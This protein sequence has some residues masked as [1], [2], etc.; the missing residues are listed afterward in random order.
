MRSGAR[1]LIAA[2]GFAA[3]GLSACGQAHQF[4]RQ[5]NGDHTLVATVD[6][7]SAN[8]GLTH[9]TAISVQEKRGLATNVATF[10][11]V[12]APVAVSWLGPEDLSICQSGTLVGHRISVDLNT[13][14]GKRTVHIHY[15][16][17]GGI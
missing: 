16:C 11:N 10:R 7:F 8:L 9:D 3:A 1:L 2:L 4:T 12:P 13:S 15:D 6:Y 17:G 14:T 5:E